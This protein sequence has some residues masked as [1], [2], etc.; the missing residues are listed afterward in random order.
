MDYN[1]LIIVDGNVVSV[2]I[3]QEEDMCTSIVEKI[4]L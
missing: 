4:D 1:T 2:D 3:F